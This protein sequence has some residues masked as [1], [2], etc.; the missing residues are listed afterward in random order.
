MLTQ[1]MN[2]MNSLI[3]HVGEIVMNRVNMVVGNDHWKRFRRSSGRRRNINGWWVK[4]LMS[5]WINPLAN[6]LFT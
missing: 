2:L 6:K 4:R 3:K 5:S 1:M